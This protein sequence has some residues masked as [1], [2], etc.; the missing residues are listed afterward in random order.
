MTDRG[1]STAEQT[2]LRENTYKH[3]LQSAYDATQTI[4]T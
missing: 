1:P 4:Y 2:E 3:V